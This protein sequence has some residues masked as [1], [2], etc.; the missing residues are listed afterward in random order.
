MEHIRTRGIIRGHGE[1]M[2]Y[3]FLNLH[4]IYIHLT[5]FPFFLSPFLPPLFTYAHMN[6]YCA[7]W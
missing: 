1:Y 4:T 7:L 5:T 2:F 3:L 6:L